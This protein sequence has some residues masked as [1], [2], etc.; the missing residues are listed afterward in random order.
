MVSGG[1]D[2]LTNYKV[3]KNY[4][5]E[6]EQ[7][8]LVRLFPK[9]GRTHQIRVHLKYINHPIFSDDLYGGRKT[10]RNDRKILSRLFLHAEK[11]TFNDPKT[12]EI[13]SCKVELTN[14]LNEL[15]EKL[16]ESNDN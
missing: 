11:I 12:N 15:L 16:K 2:S 9:T 10:A 14:D 7:L 1:R 5:L 13:I 6:S 3:E 8:S 4:M